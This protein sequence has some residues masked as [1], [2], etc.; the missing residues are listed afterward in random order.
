MTANLYTAKQIRELDR[1]AIEEQGIDGFEL[2]KKAALFTFHTLVKRWPKCKNIHVF[3]GSGNNAGDGYI[4]ASIAIKRGF[5]VNLHYLS[6]PEKLKNDALLAYNFCQKLNV[7]CQPFTSDTTSTLL[8]DKKL[9][10]KPFVIIDALLGTGLHSEVTGQYKQA[11]ELCNESKAPTLSI[12]IPSG[13]SANTGNPLGTAVQACCTA[14]FIGLKQGMFTGSG[15]NY[16]GEIFYDDLGITDDVFKK[17]PVNCKKLSINS[18]LKRI[19]PR[20][21]NAHK[22]LYGHVL[23]I[24]GDHGYGG[25]ILMAAEAAARMGAGLVSV[26]TQKEHVSAMLTRQPEV[27]V[28]AIVSEAQLL[29]LIESANILIVG[30]G[31]GQSDWSQQMLHCAL[32]SKKAVVLDADALTLLSKN[33]NW[34]THSNLILTPHP[35]EASRLLSVPKS[36]IQ[37]DRF[38]TVQSM[39]KKWGGSV[40][41]KGSG[42]LISHND[43]PIKLC[44]YGNPGMATGGMGDVLSG[45]LG[46]LIAQGLSKEDALEL[47]VCLHA[48]AADIAVQKS[49]QRGL[50]ATDLIEIARL[51]LNNKLNSRF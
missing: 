24:G 32:K 5:N 15:R 25:A 44:P 1:I 38:K 39:Q 33:S 31:L 10:D 17:V 4:L 18:C 28:R 43:G 48:K 7:S 20:E 50:L 14:T 2:M 13:L 41:L 40:L 22:G 26:A 19:Q 6:N 36:S 47:A 49:G 45:I 42:S 16:C 46:G 29:P 8:T 30:P 3:C 35:G 9:A 27:M 37:E 51:L 12:D 21:I 34:L 11:I 23:L